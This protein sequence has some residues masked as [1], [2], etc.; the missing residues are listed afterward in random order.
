MIGEFL[1][2]SDENIR[3]TFYEKELKVELEE[4]DENQSLKSR[5][6]LS[7]KGTEELSEQY[8]KYKKEK[9][10]TRV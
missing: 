1:L 10:I 9:G 4:F 5:V 3:V 8:Y 7:W 2:R 6:M